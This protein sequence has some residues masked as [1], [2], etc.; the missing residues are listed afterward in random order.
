MFDKSKQ[1]KDVMTRDVETVH[2]E[3]TLRE[4]AEKMRSLNVGPMPVCDGER[5]VGFITDRDIVV[6]AIALGHD[7]NSSRVADAMTYD[8]EYCFEDD[9]VQKAA[10]MMRDL[11]IR[12]ILVVNRDKRLVGILSLGDVSQAISDRKAGDV[13]EQISEPGYPNF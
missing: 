2:P 11:Q 6:R 4:A 9:P 8:V 3:D 10:D 1:I 7:P 12:R 5:L 13:L